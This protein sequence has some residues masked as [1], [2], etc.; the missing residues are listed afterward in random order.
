MKNAVCWDVR[1]CGSYKI[2]VAE[3]L[4]SSIVRVTRIGELG[5]TLPV[6]SNRRSRRHFGVLR[7]MRRVLGTASVVPSSPI[8]VTLM[9]EALSSSATSVLTK[10]TRRNIPED[11]I[12]H[13]QKW[14]AGPG[15]TKMPCYCYRPNRGGDPWSVIPF[16]LRQTLRV[17]APAGA[18]HLNTFGVEWAIFLSVTWQHRTLDPVPFTV[19]VVNLKY[20]L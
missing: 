4:N 19:A 3:E 6:T 9:M 2:D 17:G 11:G 18:G 20:S 8:L 5:T 13:N 15:A 7:S 1:P 12:L 14:M 16:V 10:P